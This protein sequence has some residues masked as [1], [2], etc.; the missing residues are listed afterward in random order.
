M[1]LILALFLLI[2]TTKAIA[3]DL[4]VTYIAQT[5]ESASEV[6]ALLKQHQVKYHTLQHVNWKSNYPY[7]PIAQFA[8]A[9]TPS[10]LLVS[11]RATEEGLIANYTHDQDPVFKDACME[12][13][14]QPEN[15]SIY[16][17]FECNCLG[18]IL[19]QGG[20]TLRPRQEAP[21]DILRNIKRWSSMGQMR[22]RGTKKPTSWEVALIIP[23]SSF[24]LH[25]IDSM[26]GRKAKANIYKCGGEK[27]YEHYVSWSPI[28]TR[29]PNFHVPQF[30]GQLSFTASETNNHK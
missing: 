21:E 20:T 2:S 28:K 14:I 11:Y 3:E 26:N 9:Y 1:R 29:R 24:F 23:Y 19:M 13:F 22:V 17:N 5:P 6:P 15:D 16:Y 12:L 8:L 18:Y 25:H 10:A 30:F 27:Q 4:T 7:K